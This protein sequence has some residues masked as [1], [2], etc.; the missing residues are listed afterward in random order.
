MVL[1]SLDLNPDFLRLAGKLNLLISQRGHKHYSNN[2]KISC[3][4]SWFPFTITRQS[5]T[6]DTESNML[7]TIHIFM[8]S[9]LEQPRF[10]ILAAQVTDMN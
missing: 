10:S 7:F 3:I 5:F 9:V 1:K 6:G 4:L 2:L 8:M